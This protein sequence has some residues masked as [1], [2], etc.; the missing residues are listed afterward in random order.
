LSSFDTW[1][2]SFVDEFPS[3]AI[4]VVVR[5]PIPVVRRQERIAS[6]ARHAV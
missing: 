6:S 5:Q 2:V 3:T 1:S 4:L